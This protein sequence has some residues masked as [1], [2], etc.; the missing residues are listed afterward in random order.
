MILIKY[1]TKG[2]PELFKKTIQNILDTINTRDFTILVSADI[3]DESMYNEDILNFLLQANLFKNNIKTCYGESISKIDAIN[4]DMDNITDWDMLINMSDDMK[5]ILPGWDIIIQN[6]IKETWGESTD[7]FAHF[8]D[9]YVGD[10][11]PTM[12]I[13]G[14]E[15]YERTKY[16]YHPEYKSFSCDAEAMYV[17]MMLGKHKYFP[18]IL[19]LHEH[20][21]WTKA[22]NDETYR[23]NASY[24]DF[25]VKVYYKRLNNYFDIPEAQ[26][27]CV[28]FKEHLGRYA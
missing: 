18:D 6:K 16:I 28:P 19:F 9:G 22:A 12:S 24:G 17:A 20:P 14:R 25:D 13:M 5:F 26:R 15:Y 23:I 8:N 2:R 7:Y 11:L 27:I 4:R 1:A 3:N 10:A 21:A